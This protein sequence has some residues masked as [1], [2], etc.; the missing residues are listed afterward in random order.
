MNNLKGIKIDV[1]KQT[2]EQILVENSLDGLY[3]AL[4]CD[5]IA[6]ARLN[7]NELIWLDDNGLIVDKPLGAFTIGNSRPFSGHGLILGDNGSGESC[8]TG[9]TV[10][11]VK[12]QVMF[13][14]EYELPEP[15]FEV[16]TG[17]KADEYFDNLRK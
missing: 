1:V 2:I 7:D 6:R 3:T 13:V 9:L 4:E 11:F 17:P 5:C 15:K 8:D 12:S 14:T 10:E 16:I